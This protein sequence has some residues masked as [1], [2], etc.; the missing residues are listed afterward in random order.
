MRRKS[1][2]NSTLMMTVSPTET[3]ECSVGAAAVSVRPAKAI[4]SLTELVMMKMG[5]YTNVPYKKLGL[6][7]KRKT[8]YGK[9][10]QGCK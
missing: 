6:I 7:K 10:K 4:K 3:I 2:A 8:V 1:T 9:R 5:V